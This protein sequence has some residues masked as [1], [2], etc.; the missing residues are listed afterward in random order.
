MGY[1][2]TYKLEKLLNESRFKMQIY[3]FFFFITFLIQKHMPRGVLFLEIPQNSQ[4]NTC[5]RVSFLI[6][7]QA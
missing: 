7:L 6:K 5:T 1:S 2:L 3:I 4:E